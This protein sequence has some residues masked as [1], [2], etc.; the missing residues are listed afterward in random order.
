MVPSPWGHCVGL[1]GLLALVFL[2]HKMV[3]QERPGPSALDSAEGMGDLKGKLSFMGNL[4][5]FKGNSDNRRF[6]LP[7]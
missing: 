1:L 3:P 5:L 7:H 4:R 2:L 6:L